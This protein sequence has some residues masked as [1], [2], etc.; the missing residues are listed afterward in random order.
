MQSVVLPALLLGPDSQLYNLQHWKWCLITQ[1]PG[2]CNSH[3]DC[4]THPHILLATQLW[5]MYEWHGQAVWPLVSIGK[6]YHDPW[7]TLRS[8]QICLIQR[9]TTTEYVTT[10]EVMCPGNASIST[11]TIKWWGERENNN[12][13]N[14]NEGE[15]IELWPLLLYNLQSKMC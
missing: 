6:H 14:I 13:R 2:V 8:E 10:T 3:K 4:V 9:K 7:W 11:L 12:K 1:Q 15:R 5:K